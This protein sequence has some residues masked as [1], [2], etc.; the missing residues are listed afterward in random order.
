MDAVSVFAVVI[1]ALAWLFLSR[2]DPSEP[3][4]RLFFAT[5][6]ALAAIVGGLGLMLRAIS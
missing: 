3:L 5:L 4:V 6:M 1:F 2:T